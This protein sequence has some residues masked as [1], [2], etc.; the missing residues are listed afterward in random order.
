MQSAFSNTTK[1]FTGKRVTEKENTAPAPPPCGGLGITSSCSTLRSERAH[2]CAGGGGQQ[3]WLSENTRRGGSQ[4]LRSAPAKRYSAGLPVRPTPGASS[5]NGHRLGLGADL[6]WQ[7][8]CGASS[9]PVSASPGSTTCAIMGSNITLFGL[10]DKPVSSQ[11]TGRNSVFAQLV[12][13]TVRF[14]G[15]EGTAFL[16]REGFLT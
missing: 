1:F 14:G 16:T 6:L 15:K 7:R 5:H 11:G 10:G 8:T 12:A 13:F 2:P 4:P 9:G 3:G